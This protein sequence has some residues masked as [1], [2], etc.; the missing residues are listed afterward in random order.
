MV[1]NEKL[2][3]FIQKLYLLYFFNFIFG[4][5][6][7]YFKKLN[8]HFCVKKREYIL[9]ASINLFQAT[10][11]YANTDNVQFLSDRRLITF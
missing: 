2:I 3:K 4:K 5:D 6:K 8:V 10:Q 7:R 11:K 1:S 9:S